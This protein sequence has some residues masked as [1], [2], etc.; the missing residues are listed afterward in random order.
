MDILHVSPELTLKVECLAAL[1][2]LG[3]PQPLV[4]LVDVLAQVGELLLASRALVLE[5]GK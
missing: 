2:A 1:V 5:M 3:C 4:G